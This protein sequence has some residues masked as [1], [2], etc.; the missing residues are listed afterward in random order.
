MPQESLSDERRMKEVRARPNVIFE[1]GY[2]VGK[3]GRRRVCCIYKGNVVLPSDIGGLVYKKLE[4]SLESQ[5]FSIVLELKAAGYEI[6][7]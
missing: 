4:G 5:A 2:F 7:M 1:F 6:K 3:L